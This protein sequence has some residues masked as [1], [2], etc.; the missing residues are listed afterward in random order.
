M[1]RNLP[2]KQDYEKILHFIQ[3]MEDEQS[4]QGDYRYN[5]LKNF[6]SIFSYN[7][8]TF[9]ISDTEGQ[10]TNPR[11]L[12]ISNSLFKMY[13]DYYYKKDIFNPI[14]LSE[15]LIR[16]KKTIAVTDIMPFK[17]F[18]ETE[19]YK[20]F[21]AKDSL[22]YECVVFL[23]F[24]NR[25]IGAIGIFREKEEG[26]FTPKEL[27]ILNILSDHISSNLDNYISMIQINKERQIFNNSISHLPTG[28]IIMDKNMNILNS[29]EISKNYCI[30]ILNSTFCRDPVRE[31][32][33]NIL[34]N[35]SVKSMDS[36]SVIYYDLDNYSI[37]IVPS[38]VPCLYNGVEAY[39][40]INIIKKSSEDNR[41]FND[42]ASTYNLT[43][44]EIEII[45]LLAQGFSNNKIASKLCISSNTVRTHID[46]IF[47]KLNVSS[48]TAVL[49]K[50]GIINTSGNL[51]FYT[52]GKPG[53]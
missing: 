39:Y 40:T 26:N 33:S 34:P 25:L 36:S 12:N 11:G 18:E 49:Y 15:Y 38:I 19:Y 20:D 2:A 7:H 53:L 10:L 14:N 50:L 45:E 9:F 23:Y 21:L 35:T 3:L 46:N 1:N 41:S 13:D 42:Y 22:Y 5:L 29:N 4:Y 28:L 17:Q 51:S 47:N 6:S 52:A 31:V 27:E 37:K 43:K 16:F 44:R 24:K 30:D 32:M 48:R 8:L